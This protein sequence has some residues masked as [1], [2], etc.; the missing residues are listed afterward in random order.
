[1]AGFTAPHNGEIITTLFVMVHGG[2]ASE[3]KRMM[4]RAWH[5]DA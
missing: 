4:K 1:M 3:R 2:W 5:P